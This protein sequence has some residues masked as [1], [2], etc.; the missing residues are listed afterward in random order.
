LA[1]AARSTM[2]GRLEG[3]ETLSIKVYQDNPSGKS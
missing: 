1:T 2:E 3:R